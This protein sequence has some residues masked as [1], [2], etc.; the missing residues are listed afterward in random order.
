M[1]RSRPLH[2]QPAPPRSAAAR[3]AEAE[4]L[5]RDFAA[6]TPFQRPKPFTK[7]FD[8]FADYERWRRAQRNPWNR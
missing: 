5:Y 8:S 7:S 6:L 4:R 2:A 1:P 3:L